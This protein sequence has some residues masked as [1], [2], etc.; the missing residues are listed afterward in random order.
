MRKVGVT[1]STIKWSF[2]KG[3][4]PKVK[5]PLQYKAKP[6]KM[7]PRRGKVRLD[8]KARRLE[9]RQDTVAMNYNNVKQSK[10]NGFF[11]FP[12]A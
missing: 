8:S 6:G 3:M 1:E 11:T 7:I 2:R 10:A 4:L 12:N 9:A 5:P